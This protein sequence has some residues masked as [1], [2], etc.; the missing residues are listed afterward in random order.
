MHMPQEV[1]AVR[2]EDKDARQDQRAFASGATLAELEQYIAYLR[3]LGAPGDAHPKVGVSDDYEVTMMIC[4]VE[5]PALHG[6]RAS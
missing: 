4:V 5:R 2:P 3:S 1:M 6:S